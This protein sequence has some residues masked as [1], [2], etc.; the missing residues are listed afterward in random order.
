MKIKP[1]L[2]KEQIV[3]KAIE[4]ADNGGLNAMSMRKLAAELNVQAMSLYY[5]FKTKDDLISNMVEKLV[6]QIDS[7]DSD[8]T[9]S[10]NWRTIMKNRALSAKTLF[11]KHL[12]L[13]YVI[14]SQV[15]SGVN[16]LEYLNSYLGVLRKAGFPIDKSLK[17][18]SLIDSYIY[19]FCKQL[20]HVSDNDKS[21]EE[22]A[23][24]F[25]SNFDS[26]SYPYLTEA[27]ILMMENG[28]NADDDFLFGLNV[29][30]D[31]I[32]IEL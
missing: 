7:C 1:N 18:T 12:W 28:Y 16:R 13:P 23:G 26:T 29:I 31:G 25:S 6:V 32:S 19:G 27:T 30:L 20:T 14:D 22:L 24:E 5:H 8:G 11:Q 10:Y 21:P 15:Q 2:S 4:I 17:V 3:L 9:I